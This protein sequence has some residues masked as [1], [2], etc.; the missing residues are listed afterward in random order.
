MLE[1]RALHRLS[2]VLFLVMSPLINE[3]AIALSLAANFADFENAIQSVCT[4][5]GPLL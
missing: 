3:A 1:L 5:P 2:P 4:F